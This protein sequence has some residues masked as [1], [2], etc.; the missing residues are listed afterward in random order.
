MYVGLYISWAVLVSYF[1]QLVDYNSFLPSGTDLL[2]LAVLV[3]VALIAAVAI[4][5]KLTARILTPLNS[6]AESARRIAKGDLAARAVP[7]D[8]SLGETAHLVDDFNAMAQRLQDMADGMVH[9]NAAIA[10]E[11]RTP[12]TILRGKLQGMADGVFEPDQTLLR[13]LLV[14]IDGLTRLVDDLHVVTLADS[15]R[16]S[17]QVEE[18]ALATE[19]QRVV[20]LVGPSLAE[21]GFS[22]DLKLA[23]ITVSVDAARI[24]QALIA[25]LENARRYAKRGRIEIVTRASG[26][27][28]LLSVEDEGP[29]LPPEFVPRAFEA[30]TRADPSRSR[31]LGGSGLGLSIVRAIAEAHGGKASYRGS[32]RGGAVFEI[33]I[34]HAS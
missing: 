6:L 32:P 24:R 4:A 9:W 14:Q 12:L 28:V 7:G 21:A 34:A 31:H 5:L 22:L 23:D 8:R 17:L 11:L 10:H 30:F 18:V 29:G 1:P 13:N 3:L 19:V 25:L 26:G 27:W 2:T 16:L 15:R 20:D 33:A